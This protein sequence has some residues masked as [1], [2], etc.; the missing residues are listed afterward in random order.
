MLLGLAWAPELVDPVVPVLAVEPVVPV[1]PELPVEPVL[2]VLPVDPEAPAGAV[3][4]VLPV[5]PLVAT[6]P[7]YFRVDK[8]LPATDGT[9]GELGV[10][11]ESAKLEPVEGR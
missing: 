8:V 1:D 4:P 7:V 2:L 9:S 5:D 11:F 6:V 10:L 3:V